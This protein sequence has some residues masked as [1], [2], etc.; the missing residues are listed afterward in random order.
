MFLKGFFDHSV[1]LHERTQAQTE[2][3]WENQESAQAGGK[4]SAVGF[5]FQ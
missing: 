1:N 3:G 5:T 2:K 4:L